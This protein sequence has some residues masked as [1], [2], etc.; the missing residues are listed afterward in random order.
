ML[1]LDHIVICANDKQHLEVKA[2]PH[3]DNQEE[4]TYKLPHVNY[5]VKR[6][7]QRRV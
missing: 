6:R 5:R 4:E 3:G 2:P 1:I 7:Y